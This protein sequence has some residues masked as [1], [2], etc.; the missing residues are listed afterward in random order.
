MNRLLLTIT[1]LIYSHALLNSNTP[2]TPSIPAVPVYHGETLQVADQDHTSLLQDQI[3]NLE[4]KWNILLI[5]SIALI[6]L[7]AFMVYQRNWSNKK[8]HRIIN[9]KNNLIQRQRERLGQAKLELEIR[10]LK[11]QLNPDL[12]QN[13]IYSIQQFIKEKNTRDALTYLSDFSALL[14][15]VLPSTIKLNNT[16]EEEIS[17][18]KSYIELETT[19]CNGSFPYEFDVP[20]NLD[21][22]SIRV[23]TLL[24]QPLV[25]YVLNPGLST[26]KQ[27]KKLKISFEEINDLILCRIKDYVIGNQAKE[28]LNG[29]EVNHNKSHSVNVSEQRIK[30]IAKKYKVNARIEYKNLLNNQGKVTGRGVNIYLPRIE[31]G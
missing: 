1:L 18:L 8:Y 13:S 9:E 5:V 15:N 10:M 24:L 6:A 3:R 27:Q 19:R 31:E 26:A 29:K 14:A 2:F 28:K 21:S 23:P 30:L 16:L 22:S 12:L 17:L 11:A 20:H 4:M 25:E 7:V